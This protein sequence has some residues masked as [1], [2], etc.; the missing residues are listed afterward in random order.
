MSSLQEIPDYIEQEIELMPGYTREDV[1]NFRSSIDPSGK[2]TWSQLKVFL[3]QCVEMKL[4]PRKKQIY[5]IPRFNKGTGRMELTTVISIDGF[6]LVA[7]RTG[8]YAPGS[9]TKFMTDDKGQLMAATAFVKKM[10]MDGTW[11]EVSEV[12]FLQEYKPEKPSTFW[13]KMPSVML[14]KVAEARALRRAFPGDFSG[15]YGEEEMHQA[16]METVDCE[17]RKT[18]SEPQAKQSISDEAFEKLH[19]FIKDDPELSKRLK[20]L[21]KVN[22][23]RYINEKQLEACRN[24]ARSYREKQRAATENH[25][26]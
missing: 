25:D 1:V 5:A 19:N 17:S 6:R 22:D 13:D 20:A 23:L 7:E 8:K 3:H 2:L 16:K 12:A 4:D 26:S 15:V 24:F 14:S 18:I 10:T 9:P 21:C 11:H